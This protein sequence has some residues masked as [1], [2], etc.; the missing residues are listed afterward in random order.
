MYSVGGPAALVFAYMGEF[1][2]TNVRAK[3]ICYAGAAWTISW[4]V[5]PGSF[6]FS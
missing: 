5:M 6:D 2:P 4:V 3:A 1:F